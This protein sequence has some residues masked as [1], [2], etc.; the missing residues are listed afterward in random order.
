MPSTTVHLPDPLLAKVDQAAKEKRMSRNRFIIEACENAL[1]NE[2]GQ[3][4][5]NFFETRLNHKD[6]KMLREAVSEMEAAI[7]RKRR[8]RQRVEL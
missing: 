4:P 7:I 1:N 3:W 6:I 5:D 2:A 8:S